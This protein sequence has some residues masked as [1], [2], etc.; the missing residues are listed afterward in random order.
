MTRLPRLLGSVG[1]LLCIIGFLTKLPQEHFN[2]S[3]SWRTEQEKP[4]ELAREQVHAGIDKLVIGR[5]VLPRGYTETR[6]A[7]DR[8][9]SGIMRGSDRMTQSRS[10]LQARRLLLGLQG[11]RAA[12]ALGRKATN[13]AAREWF[14]N[15]SATSRRRTLSR[16]RLP[17]GRGC[18]GEHRR[19]GRQAADHPSQRF[20]MSFQCFE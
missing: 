2:L 17:R 10:C 7:G 15:C 1:M 14:P 8:S 12:S 13:R 20:E 18:R 6:S 19:R 16:S 11:W 5:L 9:L 4:S 3:L